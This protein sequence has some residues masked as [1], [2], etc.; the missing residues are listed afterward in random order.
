MELFQLA[1][2]VCVMGLGPSGGCRG[3]KWLRDGLVL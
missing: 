2:F 1:E 3:S